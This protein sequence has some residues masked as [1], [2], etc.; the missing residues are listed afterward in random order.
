MSAAAQPAPWLWWLQQATKWPPPGW[1]SVAARGKMQSSPN[2]AGH[3][4]GSFWVKYHGNLFQAFSISW[5][6]LDPSSGSQP[7][8]LKSFQPP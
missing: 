8:L 2:P 5:S 1:A 4:L 3:S 6:F 7:V